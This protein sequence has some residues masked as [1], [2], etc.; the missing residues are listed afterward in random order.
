[1][2]LT[3]LSQVR[4]P[5]FL[6]RKTRLVMGVD[7]G[8]SVDPTAICVIEHCEGVI[9]E[10]SE[11]ERHCGLTG[12]LGLQK[13]KA[14]RW[15]VGHME[16]LALGTKYGDVV[17]HVA[18]LLA[19]PQLQADPSKN[20]NACELV[21]D[22]GGVGRGVA[23]MFTDAGLNPMCVQMT[24]GMKTNWARKN[25][26]NVPTHELITLLDARINHDRFPLTFSKHLPEGEAFKQEIADFTRSVQAAG[27]M[28]YEA[29][30]GKHD[31]MI[32]A[33]SM[34]VWWLSQPKHP[35]AQ[36]GVYGYAGA[37]WSN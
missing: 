5:K 13:K 27:R 3:E 34:A 18:G 7:L 28:R 19:A 36:F 37:T 26:W 31:D 22:A 12:G 24:G 15:R 32:M 6:P 29:R 20:Q 30:E 2:T 9:D 35:P 4:V 14:E 11:W 17:R 33:V 16:R 8:Q 21:I 1:M 10:G 23:E 25:T